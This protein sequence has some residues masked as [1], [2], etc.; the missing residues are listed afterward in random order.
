MLKYLDTRDQYHGCW[1]PGFLCH[2][3]NCCHAIVCG[4]C[5]YSSFGMNCNHLRQCRDYGVNANMFYVCSEK[6]STTRIE[7]CSQVSDEWAC[8]VRISYDHDWRNIPFL[9]QLC[10][11]CS[12]VPCPYHQDISGTRSRNLEHGMII[13]YHSILSTYHSHPNGW[14]DYQHIV[15]DLLIPAYICTTMC[16]ALCHRILR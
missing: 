8:F 5:G 13:T 16:N 12:P 11:D 15:Y 3:D 7:V 9:I 4:Q 14:H 10:G 1:C 2:Q 6:I